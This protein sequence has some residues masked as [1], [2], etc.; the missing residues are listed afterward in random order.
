MS[1]GARCGPRATSPP[2]PPSLSAPPRR[3]RELG[4]EVLIETEVLGATW[5]G[6]RIERLETSRGAIAAE[7]YVNATN[8]WAPRV[9]Q[10][11]GG[12][13]LAIAP[14]KRYLYYLRPRQTIMSENEWLG[15]PMTIYGL[16]AGRGAL[17]RPDGP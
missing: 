8:A 14:L 7:W 6:D 5:R 1:R 15:L 12:M 3:A 9:S 11:L 4:V 16:G 2:V 13:P 10:R 17:S